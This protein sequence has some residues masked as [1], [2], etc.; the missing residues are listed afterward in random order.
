MLH[1][2]MIKI[3]KH[4]HCVTAMCMGG[5]DQIDLHLSTEKF[6]VDPMRHGNVGAGARSISAIPKNSASS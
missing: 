3:L 5:H 1:A 4:L 2:Y 6:G